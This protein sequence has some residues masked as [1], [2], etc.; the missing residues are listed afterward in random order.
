MEE[1]VKN[2]PIED[3]PDDP[4]DIERYYEIPKIEIPDLVGL[5]VLDAE[6]IAFSG[7]ILPTI[8]LIDSDEAPGLVLQQNVLNCDRD[9]NENQDETEN[10]SDS[11]NEE[12]NCIGVE[13]P[14]GTE[15][16]LEVSG[17]KFTG[18]LPNIPPCSLTGEEAENIVKDFMR[19]TNV[20]LFLKN[21]FEVTEL[22]NCKGKVIG[23]NFPQGGS[24][25]TGDSLTFIIGTKNED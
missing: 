17:K 2:L 11:L 13:M 1:V 14:E 22:E 4:L 7:Y 9:G 21:S 3:W 12:D 8:N 20:I 16:I 24:V 23:T 5:N 10:N 18:D 15:V 19:E 25:S 6:E